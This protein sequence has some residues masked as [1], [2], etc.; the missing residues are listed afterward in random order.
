MTAEGNSD[1][2]QK[3]E[4][5]KQGDQRI[6]II[7]VVKTKTEDGGSPAPESNDGSDAF[8]RY[9]KSSIQMM[10]LNQPLLEDAAE[11][12]KEGA[13]AINAARKTR[14]STELHCSVFY[15]ELMMMIEEL[16]E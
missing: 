14:L 13:V 12:A 6:G 16:Q 5:T 7:Y 9:S 8:S 15:E 11:V 2:G 1:V 3:R 10:S 4:E